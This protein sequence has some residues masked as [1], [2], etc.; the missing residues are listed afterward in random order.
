MTLIID[1][2]GHFTTEPQ[3]HHDFRKAQVAFAE[4][5]ASARPIYP[6]ISDEELFAII[7]ANQLQLQKERGSNLT[8]ISPRASGMG[9]HIGGADVA[10]EWA[11]HL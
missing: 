10:T 9:H 3:K 2:H 5:K 7:K 11:A 8:I 1:C 6:G 4:G